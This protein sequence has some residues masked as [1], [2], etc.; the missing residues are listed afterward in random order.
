MP[1]R[2]DGRCVPDRSCIVPCC[3]SRLGVPSVAR[4]ICVELVRWGVR[5]GPSSHACG[6]VEWRD[7]RR[8]SPDAAGVL[9]DRCVL[10]DRNALIARRVVHW[11]DPRRDYVGLEVVL[12]SWNA[13]SHLKSNVDLRCQAIEGRSPSF[14]PPTGTWS[15]STGRF[16]K[17]CQTG[18]AILKPGGPEQDSHGESDRPLRSGG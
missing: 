11:H 2:D 14:C 1:C 8:R 13:G 3:Q 6:D 4:P 5:C 18:A 16:P 12:A 17:H 10:C 15:R 7:P 9:C